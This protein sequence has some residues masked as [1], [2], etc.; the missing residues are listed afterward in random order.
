MLQCL[1]TDS[2]RSNNQTS[3]LRV[4][5]LSVACFAQCIATGSVAYLLPLCAWFLLASQPNA[6]FHVGLFNWAMGGRLDKPVSVKNPFRRP[7]FA[8]ASLRVSTRSTHP[9]NI[10]ASSRNVRLFYG[11]DSLRHPD[12]LQHEDP[13]PCHYLN[14]FI[15][16]VTFYRNMTCSK[17]S[18]WK[19]R[20]ERAQPNYSPHVSTWIKVWRRQ[21]LFSHLTLDWLSSGKSF[22]FAN[23]ITRASK[24]PLLMP[25]SNCVLKLPF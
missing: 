1:Q 3:L 16:F 5:P 22:S 21:N 4:A 7:R 20:C 25:S 24:H 13:L 15:C 17:R 9:I 10:L 8:S 11:N 6:P 14:F 12:Q 23:Q 2:R 18:T 19:S